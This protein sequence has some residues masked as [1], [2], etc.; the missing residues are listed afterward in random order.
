MSDVLLRLLGLA[1]GLLVGL[2]PAAVLVW[3]QRRERRRWEREDQ[4]RQQL[5]EMEQ[6]VWRESLP[7]WQRE[8]VE[9]A[10]RQVD[11]LGWTQQQAAAIRA[12]DWAAVDV[13]HVAEEVE[14]LWKAAD[15]ALTMLVL[16]C[17]ELVYRPCP[18]E[19][20]RYYWQPAVIDHHRA[21]LTKSL[22]ES[23]RL[24]PVPE[25][26]LAEA[27]AWARECV[28]RRHTPPRQEPPAHC[29][30]PLEALLDERSWFDTLTLSGQRPL[31]LRVS[32]GVAHAL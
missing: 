7:A 5:W 24:K 15:H 28:M 13:A 14:D 3:W 31:T 26:L 27:C 30:W 10:D 12:R 32:K 11:F 8:A 23:P 21:M 18:R 25:G 20:D 16:G 19:D 22:E 6:L 1:L 9:K 29:P 2:A 17:L 4:L